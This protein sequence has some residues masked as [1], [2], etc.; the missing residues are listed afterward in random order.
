MALAQAYYR[1]KVHLEGID[2]A[3]IRAHKR[4]DLLSTI[5]F[6]LL[7]LFVLVTA[8]ILWRGLI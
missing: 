5:A 6:N 2:H 7:F 4:A 3:G 8:F 1:C